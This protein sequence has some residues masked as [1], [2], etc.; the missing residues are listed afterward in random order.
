MKHLLLTTIA[1]VVL[2]GCGTTQSQ[3][4]AEVK[5]AEPVL[6]VAKPANPIADRALLDAA[7][8]GKIEEVKKAIAAGADVNAKTNDGN[9]PL[10]Y[11]V[12]W[13]RRYPFEEYKEVV[14]LLIAAGADVNAKDRV[15]KTPLDRASDNEKP[16][17]AALLRKHG[18]KTG[19]ELKAAGN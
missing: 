11:S 10:F 4:S 18:G 6:G 9:T 17:T 19:A 13:E 1:A 16:E 8:E 5:S 7:K 14:E 15:G 12:R 3:K 2:V